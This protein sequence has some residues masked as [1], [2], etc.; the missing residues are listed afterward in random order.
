MFKPSLPQDS[1]RETPGGHLAASPFETETTHETTEYRPSDKA[2][3][4]TES[5]WDYFRTKLVARRD[6]ILEERRPQ[7]GRGAP[8]SAQACR[9]RMS[10]A[11]ESLW[12]RPET[13]LAR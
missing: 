7:L 12:G 2:L 1:R 9:P 13:W 10:R 4:M 5:Q 3:F 8:A 11:T 6:E